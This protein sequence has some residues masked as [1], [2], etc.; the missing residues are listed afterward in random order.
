MPA[1]PDTPQVP[2]STLA[3]VAHP[4]TATVTAQVKIAVKNLFIKNSL[5]KT[6]ILFLQL[7]E[8]KP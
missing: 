8:E 3:V 7:T 2:L 1:F 5:Q 4:V 6:E